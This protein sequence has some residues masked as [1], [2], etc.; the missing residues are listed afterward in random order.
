MV[1][2]AGSGQMHH[3]VHASQRVPVDGPFFGTPRDL[4]GSRPATNDPDHVVS[5][6]AKIRLQR[7]AD[8]PA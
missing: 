2:D 3:T 1:T 4:I 5:I 7:R 8:K 6:G